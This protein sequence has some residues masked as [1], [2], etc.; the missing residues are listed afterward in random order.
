[1]FNQVID[2]S[3]PL[4]PGREGRTFEIEVLEATH[5]TG[6]EAEQDW[7]IMH[8][9]IMDNHIG[10]HL[11][12][13]YHTDSEGA[14]LAQ[15]PVEQFVGEAAILDLRGHGA[16]EA[17]SLETVQQAADKAGGVG[18][19]DI[20]FA[21][22]GWSQHYGSEQY[23]T[24]PFLSREALC[25]LLDQGT[26]MLGVDTPGAMDPNSP[27]RWNHLPIFEAGAVYIENL[28][29]LETVPTSRATVRRPGGCD[30][31]RRSA[32]LR[33]NRRP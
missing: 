13:P 28:T 9:V 6:A 24:P 16:H 4:R 17:I 19:G 25:W 15:V 30:R 26:K 5:I 1:M 7:Y 32:D 18:E 21:M 23:M 3:H 8:R 29:N 27:D 10:T 14:D 31:P 20:V 11:E 2:L 12:V 33:Q 22:T